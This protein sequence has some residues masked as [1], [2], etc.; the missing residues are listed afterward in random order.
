MTQTV[1]VAGG[2][3][4][5]GNRIAHYLL[6]E[7]DAEVR[8]LVRP[9]VMANAAKSALVSPLLD[10]GAHVIEGDLA[11]RASLERATMGVNV[12]VSAVQGGP[13]VIVEGQLALA[14]AARRNGVRR[15]L[16]SDFALDFFEHAEGGHMMFDMRRKADKAIAA[17]GLEHVHVLNGAFMDVF[18]NPWG[19][20]MF[21]MEKGVANTWGD[22]DERF[23]TTSI[24]DT[25]RYTAKAALDRGVPSGKFAVSGQ[26]TSFEEITRALEQVTGRTFKRESRGSVAELK[27]WIDDTR[28]SNPD[29]MATI[30][31]RYQ[32]YMLIG[33]VLQN[34]QNSR[35]PDIVPETFAQH[36][37]RTDRGMAA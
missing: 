25:A 24:E 6:K 34:V 33:P 7:P 17:S 18:L 21:D 2:T 3:G 20:P 30:A 8:L 4:V 12:I 14:E 28:A 10:R 35:Y 27:V 11:D 22:G 15:I 19:E 1:L 5:L 37:A 13:D 32:L 36:V 29:P 9:G 31:A 26:Q 23:D 16:P